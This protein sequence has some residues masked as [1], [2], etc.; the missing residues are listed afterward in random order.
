M[1]IP[2]LRG[3]AGAE[4]ADRQQRGLRKLAREAERLERSRR[5]RRPSAREQRVEF[6]HDALRA[7]GELLPKPQTRAARAGEKRAKKRRGRGAA[8]SRERFIEGP[9]EN[10]ASP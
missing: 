6:G 9:S 1:T 2:S 8:R 7:L 3:I 5:P 4:P 10:W